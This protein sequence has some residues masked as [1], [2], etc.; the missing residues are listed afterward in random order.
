MVNKA[1]GKNKGRGE[2][3]EDP[4]IRVRKEV[5]QKLKRAK[6]ARGLLQDLEEEVRLF[7]R[8]WNEKER[9]ER[10]GFGDIDSDEE[11]VVF[12]GRN[13]QMHDSP[14]RKRSQENVS[15]EKLVFDGLVDDSGA[16]F[17][18]VFTNPPCTSPLLTY[19]DA[20]WYIP[21]VHTM[22]CVPGRLPS[23]ILQDEKHTSESITSNS[24]VLGAHP[25]MEHF[26]GL[27]GGW[28]EL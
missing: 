6:A 22:G 23:E 28:C 9:K 2:K 15:K 13:G 11:E 4:A 21:L 10:D 25:R 12:V 20:G 1:A 24:L 5:R 7:V 16:S 14:S 8:T 3:V 17:G 19:L 26:R 27:C 18:Y